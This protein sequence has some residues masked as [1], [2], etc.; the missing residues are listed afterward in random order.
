MARTC[1]L[2]FGVQMAAMR[3]DCCTGLGWELVLSVLI[4]HA[5]PGERLPFKLPVS[6]RLHSAPTCVL[7]VTFDTVQISSI[8][9]LTPLAFD[10]A[11]FRPGE[12]QSDGMN[13]DGSC[14]ALRGMTSKANA[15]CAV[16]PM[17]VSHTHK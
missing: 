17:L 11:A 1:F 7:H 9:G 15:S 8:T 14:G 4:V 10:D 3:S 13:N 5:S 16:V 6:K 2:R 12:I